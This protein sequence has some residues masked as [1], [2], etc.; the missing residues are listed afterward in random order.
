LKILRD[1]WQADKANCKDEK[2]KTPGVI[3]LHV[4]SCGN[5]VFAG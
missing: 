4:Q 5:Q 1:G 2:S 3:P